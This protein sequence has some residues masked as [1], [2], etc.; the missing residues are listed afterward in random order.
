LEV[1]LMLKEGKK[2]K[3]RM[4]KGEVKALTSYIL[5][6]P[7]NDQ[8]SKDELSLAEIF[9]PTNDSIL[10]DFT[11][12]FEVFINQKGYGFTEMAQ[13]LLEK[14]G[15][16]ITPKQLKFHYLRN[17]TLKEKLESHDKPDQ[18]KDTS[19]EK[20]KSKRLIN[21]EKNSVKNQEEN[22]ILG[23]DAAIRKEEPGKPVSLFRENEELAIL[24]DDEY[25][26]Y[27]DGLSGAEEKEVSSDASLDA[28]PKNKVLNPEK[29]S[30]ENLASS[31][32]KG[33]KSAH[34]GKEPLP[35][36]KTIG[37]NKPGSF[38]IDMEN[39]PV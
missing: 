34:S 19:S 27:N 37:S 32:S 4:Q 23:S 21:K 36:K 7:Q 24:D 33:D 31:A 11:E 39:R 18:L 30:K 5:S 35:G 2:Q 28:S 25:P 17:K 6:L 1:D 3:K 9:A 22:L 26:D 14:T 10:L 38:V 29:N 20:K 8:G 15:I 16:A 13:I 12:A